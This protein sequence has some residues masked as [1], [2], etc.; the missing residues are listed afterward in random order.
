[1]QTFFGNF[2]PAQQA[3]TV[4]LM[5]W[6]IVSTVI[7]GVSGVVMGILNAHQHFLLPALAPVMYNLSIILAALFLGPALGVR[8][9]TAGVVMAG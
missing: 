1:M 9:L 3:L 2:D 7:F 4:E 8:G 5:R 6:M